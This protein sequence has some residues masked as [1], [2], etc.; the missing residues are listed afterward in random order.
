MSSVD[1]GS[2]L[3]REELPRCENRWVGV[4]RK[5]DGLGATVGTDHDRIGVGAARTEAGKK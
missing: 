5:H 3:A 4:V 2:L 1:A